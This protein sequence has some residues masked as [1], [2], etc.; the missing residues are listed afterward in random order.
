MGS[1]VFDLRL[2]RKGNVETGEWADRDGLACA[3][4]WEDKAMK[5]GQEL[6]DFVVFYAPAHDTI[7]DGGNLED[8]GRA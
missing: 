8:D 6:M 2:S 7:S 4:L 5:S 3:S 1:L